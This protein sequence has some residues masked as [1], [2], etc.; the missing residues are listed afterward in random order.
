MNQ[1][2]TEKK[3]CDICKCPNDCGHPEAHCKWI[4][5]GKPNHFCHTEAKIGKTH[6]EVCPE[7]QFEINPKMP[8]HSQ[9]CSKYQKLKFQDMPS[10]EGSSI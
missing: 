1:E 6:T 2:S 7:C 9:Q 8:F 5:D 4:K 10:S 3:C